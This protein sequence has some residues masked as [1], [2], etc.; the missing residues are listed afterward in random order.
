VLIVDFGAGFWLVGC[1]LLLGTVSAAH[2]SQPPACHAHKLPVAVRAH[3]PKETASRGSDTTDTGLYTASA[4]G[5]AVGLA[6]HTG[7]ATSVLAAAVAIALNP[8][9]RPT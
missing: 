8:P 9:L 5:A 2:T 3:L 1:Q 4:H 6:Q 7:C